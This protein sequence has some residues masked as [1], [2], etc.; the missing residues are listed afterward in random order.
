KRSL[1]LIHHLLTPIQDV[2]VI[3]TFSFPVND[4]ELDSYFAWFSK[5]PSIGSVPGILSDE[6]DPIPDLPGVR[7]MTQIQHPDKPDEKKWVLAFCA[8]TSRF[9]P[10]NA[11]EGPLKDFVTH[12]RFSLDLYSSHDFTNDPTHALETSWASVFLKPSETK[13]WVL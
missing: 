8:P 6:S 9:N 5:L 3:F 10:V 13:Y 12:L 1:E 11:H 4:P 7:F 2:L